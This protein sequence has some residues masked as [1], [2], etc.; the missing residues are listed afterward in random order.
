MWFGGSI[1]RLVEGAANRVNKRRPKKRRKT[2]R[3]EKPA[4]PRLVRGRG[5]A[6]RRVRSWFSPETLVYLLLAGALM[7][8]I[9]KYLLGPYL[10][11]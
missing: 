7:H 8:F 9:V 2:R 6:R 10:P 3:D 4:G 11:K 1:S 5:W